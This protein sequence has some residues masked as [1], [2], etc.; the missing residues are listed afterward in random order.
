MYGLLSDL[1]IPA[2]GYPSHL[3]RQMFAP[4]PVTTVPSLEGFID[5]RPPIDL[6]VF[7]LYEIIGDNHDP[8]R[9][10]APFNE[11]IRHRFGAKEL[12]YNLLRVL[13]GR[14]DF[15]TQAVIGTGTGGSY[16][17]FLPVEEIRPAMEALFEV[18]EE[19]LW[20]RLF[21]YYNC[22][23]EWIHPLTDGNGRSARLLV[24]IYLRA[25]GV[26]VAVHA[27]NKIMSFHGFQDMIMKSL[28]TVRPARSGT[29]IPDTKRR[30]SIE[31]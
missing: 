12:Y 3:F 17:V 24:T 1:D 20:N 31:V 26:P 28:E 25:R 5:R 11:L 18:G 29:P 21:R 13:F 7:D 16:R 9:D 8:V 27:G 10:V 19:S 14:T 22:L 2:G 30:T 23:L 15:R 6:S 4:L